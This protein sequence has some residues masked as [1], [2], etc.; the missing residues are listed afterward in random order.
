MKVRNF[1]L[2]RSL[3]HAASSL[4]V[5]SASELLWTSA[6]L[7]LISAALCAGVWAMEVLKSRSDAFKRVMFKLLGAI[8]RDGEQHNV[9]SATWYMSSLFLLSLTFSKLPSCM[10]ALALGVGDPAAALVGSKLGHVRLYGKKTL[11]GSAAF[12]IVSF[13]FFVG[14]MQLIYKVAGCMGR[15]AGGKRL[16]AGYQGASGKG[17]RACGPLR[18]TRA[19]RTRSIRSAGLTARPVHGLPWQM[20][21]EAVLQ[22]SAVGSLCGAVAE[23]YCP[24]TVDD[25]LFV[26]VATAACVTLFLAARGDALGLPGGHVEC[27]PPLHR[28]TAGCGVFAC[29]APLRRL[30]PHRA[31]LR[32]QSCA[33]SRACPSGTRPSSTGRSWRR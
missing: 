16:V 33:S 8:S 15:R 18:F 26:P 32:T 7:V 24:V 23:L 11:E 20:P 22:L 27:V 30:S 10:G 4:M 6:D 1:K 25:N 19:I 9:N 14:Y 28:C 13:A 17:L 21:W 5:V 31:S 3:Y 29:S 2:A 12:A